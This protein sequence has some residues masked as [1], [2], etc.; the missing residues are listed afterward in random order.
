MLE[1][2]QLQTRQTIL[3]FN[4][5]VEIEKILHKKKRSNS[6]QY[7]VKWRGYPKRFNSWVDES[8]IQNIN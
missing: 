4:Y 8:A 3:F 5:I 6:M 1:V 7:F 2:V